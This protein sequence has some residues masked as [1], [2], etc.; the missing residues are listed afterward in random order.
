[1]SIFT[2]KNLYNAYL[3]CRKNKRKTA[4][5]LEFETDL[6]NKLFK[7][8]TELKNHKY[9]PGK[10]ICFAVE[11]PKTR[12]IFAAGF[13]D[14]VVHH[15]LLREILEMSE[16][17][18]FFNSF[19]CRKNKGTHKAVDVLRKYIKKISKNGREEVFFLQ[20]D[21]SSFFISIDHGIL[22]KIFMKFIEK[23]QKSKKWKREI[24]WLAKQIIF[25]KPQ[26]NCFVRGDKELLYSVP[27]QKSLFGAGKGNGLPIGNYSSQFFANLYL[28]ELDYFIKQKLRMKY[29]V[30]Y[31]DD[32]ILF[33]YNKDKLEKIILKISDFLENELM[34]S[35]NSK[36]TKLKNIKDGIDFLGYF[37]KP[38]HVLVRKRVVGACRKKIVSFLLEKP[39]EVNLKKTIACLNSYFGH[40]RHA[41][42]FNLRKKMALENLKGFDKFLKFDKNFSFLRRAQQ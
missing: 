31:V 1:M 35:L 36:K 21:L 26:D 18:L 40:F 30:R 38:D 17:C 2:Y 22:Y 14:R 6:E 3:E 28:N 29:Y 32:F 9:M 42:S 39:D 7:L 24:L 15:L 23:Q 8:L 33:D 27:K 41:D 20:L 19:A 16:K 13:R 4:S 11:Y 12:E 25:H 5:A 37:I 34:L 10:S